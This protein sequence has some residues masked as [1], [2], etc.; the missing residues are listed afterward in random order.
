[1]NA[2]AARTPAAQGLPPDEAGGETA[3]AAGSGKVKQ[4]CGV[5]PRTAVPPKDAL[6]PPAAPGPP[7]LS[8]LLLLLSAAC[9]TAPPPPS[10]DRYTA[11]P[12]A[13]AAGY[14]AWYGDA[15]GGLLFFGESAFW[16]A[17]R[18]HGGDATADLAVGGPKRIGRFNL[19]AERME[20]AFPVEVPGGSGVWDVLA[21]GDQVYFTTFFGPAGMVDMARGE[22]LVFHEA[23]PGLNELARG[24]GGTLLA[25]RYGAPGGG[26]GSIV[27]MGGDGRVVAELP[28]EAPPGWLAA[29][30]TVAYD[31]VRRQIWVTVDLVPQGGGAARQDARRLRLDGRELARFDDPELQFVVFSG[32]GTGYLAARS[33]RQLALLVLEPLAPRGDP[34]LSARRIVL[35]DDFDPSLDFAQDIHLSEDGRVV[36][37]RW[38]GLVHVVRPDVDVVDTV[39]FP[40]EGGAGLYYSAVLDGKRLCATYCA[41]VQVVCTDAPVVPP[42][43]RPPRRVR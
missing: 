36:V 4:R 38:S 32:D 20:P 23:G 10:F 21:A 42:P 43:S 5:A 33:G 27:M 37:T 8:A 6:P 25:S 22:L 3:T 15:E 19:S 29:P 30:K 1:M 9:A 7:A 35:D 41:G 34:I 16:A 28:L 13:E 26:Q 24:P 17:T 39:A 18:G 14:C 2:P 11:P 31:P 40:R 12:A